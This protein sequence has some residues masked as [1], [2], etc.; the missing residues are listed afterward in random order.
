MLKIEVHLLHLIRNLSDF[1]SISLINQDLGLMK[2]RMRLLDTKPSATDRVKVLDK[3]KFQSTVK[4]SL[5]QV[6]IPMVSNNSV[7]M[8]PS[9]LLVPNVH[10]NRILRV[11]APVPM[12]SKIRL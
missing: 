7:Q 1:R 12:I 5:A 4:I 3:T 8:F 6:P 11:R 9:S 2:L 10:L